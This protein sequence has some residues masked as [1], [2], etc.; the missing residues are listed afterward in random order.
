VSLAT[1]P[2]LL[3]E[4]PARDG[5]P[6]RPLALRPAARIANLM[7]WETEDPYAALLERF[8]VANAI[9]RREDAEPWD[10]ARARAR[11]R[12][13]LAERRPRVLICLGRRAAAAAGHDGDWY[14]WR[15]RPGRSVAL[16][17]HPSGRNHAWNDPATAGRVRLLLEAALLRARGV[18]PPAPAPIDD[19]EAYA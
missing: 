4:S 15:D 19:L 5:D 12:A 6:I 16:A 8:D 13:L 10:P 9:E 14:E 7:G 11:V 2:L 3:G 18:E 17:P 1:R